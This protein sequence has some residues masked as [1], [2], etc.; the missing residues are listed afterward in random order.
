MKINQAKYAPLLK[1]HTTGR[2][3]VCVCVSLCEHACTVGGF[4]YVCVCVCVCAYVCVEVFHS[5]QIKNR[6]L[7][8]DSFSFLCMFYQKSSMLHQ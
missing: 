2:H 5:A 3:K 6:S 1:A 4:V 8:H 7:L